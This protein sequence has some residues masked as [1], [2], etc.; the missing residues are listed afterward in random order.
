MNFVHLSQ[1]QITSSILSLIGGII[2]LLTAFIGLFWFALGGPAW[3]GFGGWMSGMMSG[4]HGWMSGAV[5]YGLYGLFSI[6]SVIGLISGIIMIFGA[7]MLRAKP[8]EHV[9]WGV[10][11][12]IFA[13]VSLVDMGGYFIG[14][15]L[16]I[17]GGAMA[18]SYRSK[19]VSQS[20]Q[21]A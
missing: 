17:A 15:L 16:G 1:G 13:V 7:A 6:V 11:I 19:M 14:A 3:G 4:Y 10:L 9:T 8:Q 21:A 12:I 20:P 5:G 2:V 18:L